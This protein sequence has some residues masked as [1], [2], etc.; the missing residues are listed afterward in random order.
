LQFIDA[1]IVDDV[2]RCIE[3]FFVFFGQT[4]WVL[5]V[6]VAFAYEQMEEMVF[7]VDRQHVFDGGILSKLRENCVFEDM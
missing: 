1:I 3:I 7:G 4:K 5:I 6:V 2:Q